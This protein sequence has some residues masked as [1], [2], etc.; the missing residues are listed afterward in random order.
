MT[1]IGAHCRPVRVV[2]AAAPPLAGIPYRTIT[3]GA[4]DLTARIV[5]A[6]VRAPARGPRRWW[7]R[8]ARSAARACSSSSTLWAGP[9][10]RISRRPPRLG[11]TLS[12]TASSTRDPFWSRGT[13]HCGCTAS[14]SSTLPPTPPLWAGPHSWPGLPCEVVGSV[15]RRQRCSLHRG[16]APPPPSPAAHPGSSPE[17]SSARDQSLPALLQ[18]SSLLPIMPGISRATARNSAGQPER[19]CGRGQTVTAPQPTPFALPGG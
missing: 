13:G 2:P 17:P 1:A 11:A 8:R 16:L 9:V 18:C 5:A 10:S 7:S 6:R 4:P 12:C 14:T 15:P 19:R 3:T